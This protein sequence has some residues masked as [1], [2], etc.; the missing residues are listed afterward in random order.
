MELTFRKGE[1]LLQ[2][3]SFHKDSY[4]GMW[5]SSCAGHISFGDNSLET[6][7]KELEEE[8]GI[9][10]EEKDFQFIKRVVVSDVLNDGMTIIANL[11]ENS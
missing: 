6:C 2:Q 11:K 10:S 3:R 1:I 4:P 8:L 5:D 9:K 7:V